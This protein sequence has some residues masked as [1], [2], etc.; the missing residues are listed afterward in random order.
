MRS[1]I[2]TQGFHFGPSTRKASV[3]VVVT[4]LMLSVFG[5]A[6]APLAQTFPS[7]ISSAIASN[8]AF[9]ST[10][11]SHVGFSQ[12]V[13]RF[14]LFHVGEMILLAI[15]VPITIQIMANTFPSAISAVS[16]AN[17]TGWTSAA[18]SLW[19]SIVPLLVVVAAILIPIMLVLPI[20][21]GGRL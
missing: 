21:S 17:E 14:A 19:N 12:V 15:F 13:I 10:S 3:L 6:S 2:L 9:I 20:E 5:M 8:G 4:V 16:T 1:V 11:V 18:K 7:S